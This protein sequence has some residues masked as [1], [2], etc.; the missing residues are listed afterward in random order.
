[1]EMLIERLMKRLMESGTQESA[2]KALNQ[3]GRT[4]ES[5]VVML[6]HI[7]L[8]Y[9]A[10]GYCCVQK[11]RKRLQSNGDAVAPWTSATGISQV[12]DTMQ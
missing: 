2:E 5:Q 7:G 12:G 10:M 1:M 6:D 9:W 3:P 11:I 8:D 4:C